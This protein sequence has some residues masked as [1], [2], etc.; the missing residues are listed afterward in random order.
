MASAAVDGGITLSYV[1][2][3][4]LDGPAVVFLPGP[5]DSWRS[6]QPVLD[7]M[8]AQLRAVAVSLRGHGE[9]SKPPAGYRIGDLASDVVPFLDALQI[10]RAVLVGHSGSC[11]AARRVAIDSPERVAG[12]VLEAAPTTLRGDDRLAQFVAEVVAPLTDPV[13]RDLARSFVVDTATAALDSALVERLVDDVVAVPAVAWREMFASVLEHDDTDELGA[14][15]AP[16]LLVWGDED[17][18]VP[19][20]MQDQLVDLLPQAELI[21]YEGVGHTPRW[22]LP[23]R[24]AEDVAR[25]AN[26]VPR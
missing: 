19:R 6:Y 7:C 12:L 18:L 9:S 23:E 15:A 11:L 13:D 21:V 1:E 10:E 17:E 16:V 3:G 24:F 22:E 20:S 25:F 14:L 4:D 26:A 5:T 8:P 2:Q